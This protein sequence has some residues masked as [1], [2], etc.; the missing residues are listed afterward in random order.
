MDIHLNNVLFC[1]C[2]PHRSAVETETLHAL[3]HLCHMMA[4][5]THQLHSEQ[6]VPA[7]QRE[8]LTNSVY[9]HEHFLDSIL[10]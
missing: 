7:E 3:L 2:V 5:K 8:K 6:Q 4:A 1:F 9:L 10:I